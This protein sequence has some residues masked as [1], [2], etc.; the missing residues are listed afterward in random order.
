MLVYI[1][2][3]KDDKEL[4]EHCEYAYVYEYDDDK[5][6]YEE[7]SNTKLND[8]EINYEV[9]VDEYLVS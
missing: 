1:D 7:D 3:I 8:Y 2:I 4:N 5:Y 9:E 6:D